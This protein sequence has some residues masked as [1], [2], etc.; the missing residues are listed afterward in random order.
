MSGGDREQ[1]LHRLG[2][3]DAIFVRR[4]AALARDA[5]HAIDRAIEPER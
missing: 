4:A 5:H 1:S 3:A 2:P